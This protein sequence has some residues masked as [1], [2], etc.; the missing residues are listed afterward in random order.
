[1]N[2][3][4]TIEELSRINFYDIMMNMFKPYSIMGIEPLTH[5]FEL[6]KQIPLKILNTLPTDFSRYTPIK[7]TISNELFF[8]TPTLKS[9]HK[10]SKFENLLS[11]PLSF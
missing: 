3:I 7:Q 11:P 1:M 8:T 4:I 9:N 2:G 6:V 5:H 10:I